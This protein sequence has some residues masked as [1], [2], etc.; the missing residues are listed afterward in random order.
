METEP[1]EPTLVLLETNA[2]SVVGKDWYTRLDKVFIGNLGKYRKY[3]GS[4][5]R[6]ILRALRNKVCSCIS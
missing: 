1:P 6:D 5:V 4:S 2:V 3:R